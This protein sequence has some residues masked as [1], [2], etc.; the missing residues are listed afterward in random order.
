MSLWTSDEIAKATDGKTAGTWAV[1]GVS[2][3]SRTVAKGDLFI[4]L[5]G[6]THDGH[7][8]VGSA[9][10]AGA[11]G[12]LVHRLPQDLSHHLQ[13]KLVVVK[14]T[15]TALNKLGAAARARSRAKIAAITGSVGKTGTKEALKLAFGALGAT[16]ATLGN[17]NNHW[18]VPLTLS[19]M[20]R[21]AAF[22]VFE[23]GMN[24][25]GEIAPL[26]KLVQAHVAIVTTVAA[27]HLEFFQ[28]VGEIADEKASIAAGLLPGGTMIL[29]ADNEHYDRMASVA[30]AHGVANIVSFGTAG[31]A[32]AQLIGMA[33]KPTGMQVVTDILGERV[34]YDLGVTGK[35]WALNTIAVLAAVK[36]VGGDIFESAAALSKLV[37]SKGR[38]LRTEVSVPGGSV[39]VIDETYNA[40]PVSIKALADTLGQMKTG[41]VKR[42][43]MV[44]GDMLELGTSGPALHADLAEAIN[45][46]RIDAVFTAGPLMEHLHSALPREKRG[47]HAK[48]SATLAP[49]VAAAAKPGDLIA[50]K[51]SNG[52]K[53]SVVVDTLLGLGRGAAKAANGH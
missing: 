43:I 48:D 35:Q 50:V 27:A 34:T 47:G 29:P 11:A 53:M 20:P 46:N 49:L 1:E 44:L 12:S 21:E 13:D 6:P 33:F 15:F 51:G 8:H 41:Q 26:A 45:D 3:D 36:A 19:R 32:Q 17:L 4:A 18:G 2:I 5:Q 9:L 7:D 25:A 37:P 14:D 39:T 24:H 22:G 31:S 30:K 40:S 38:G 42:I 52:S 10:K 16:H 28:S 23:L